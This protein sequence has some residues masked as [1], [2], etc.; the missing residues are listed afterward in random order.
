MLPELKIKRT[1]MPKME[2]GVRYF[3]KKLWNG[4][5]RYAAVFPDGTVFRIYSTFKPIR[6]WY[7]YG[8]TPVKT[9]LYSYE[10]EEILPK[11]MQVD[12]GL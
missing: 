12:E 6:R 10:Y 3:R 2:E 1:R 7:I 11:Y 8:D 9:L 4:K 5:H